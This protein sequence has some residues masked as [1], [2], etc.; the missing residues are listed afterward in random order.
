MCREERAATL[1]PFLDARE[2]EF[3]SFS[4]LSR[5][6]PPAEIASHPTPPRAHIPPR[7]DLLRVPGPLPGGAVLNARGASL[8][9]GGECEVGSPGGAARGRLRV[10]RRES[11]GSPLAYRGQ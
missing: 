7:A 4:S 5:R 3:V 9:A 1:A 10:S 2:I 6:I 8:I 11:A